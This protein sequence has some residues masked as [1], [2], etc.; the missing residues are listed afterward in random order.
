MSKF[1]YLIF[2]IFILTHCSIDNKSGIWL[3]KHKPNS[4]IELS[5]INFDKKLTFVEFRKNVVL[6]AKKSRYPNIIKNND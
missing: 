4:N 6:Y 5:K 1:T 2:F 3:D